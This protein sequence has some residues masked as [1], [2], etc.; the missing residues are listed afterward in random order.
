MSSRRF[1]PKG[2]KRLDTSVL[3]KIL[4]IR[5]DI[6]FLGSP[7]S[8]I[9]SYCTAGYGVITYNFTDADRED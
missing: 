1:R 4:L 8:K 5:L 3:P 6:L 2:R 7:Q 9:S